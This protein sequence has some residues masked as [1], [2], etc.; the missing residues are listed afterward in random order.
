LHDQNASGGLTRGKRVDKTRRVMWILNHTAA[1]KFEVPMLRKLGYEVFTPK[2]YPND[3]N[4]RSAS[5]D[6]KWDESLTIPPEDLKILNEADW[7]AGANRYAWE[8]ANKY[9]DILFCILFD[10][11]GV[12]KTCRNFEGDVLWRTYGLAGEEN[13]YSK[14]LK[15]IPQYHRAKGAFRQLGSRFWFAEG[16]SNL[17]EVEDDWI[18][19]SAVH[20]PLGMAEA[21]SPVVEP[22]V[23]GD[24]RVLFVCP[25]IG[26]NSAY[27]DIYTE[28]KQH[29]R[30]IPHA[31]GGA[32]SIKV[33]DPNVL[34]YLPLKE[35]QENMTHL[36]CMFYHSREP[37]HIHYHPFEAI[38]IGMP[39]IFMSGGMLDRMGGAALPGRAKTWSEARSKVQRLIEGDASFA[40]AVR[41][42]Q[43]SLLNDMMAENLEE[44]WVRGLSKIEAAADRREKIIDGKSRRVAIITSRKDIEKAVDAA[45]RL[46]VDASGVGVSLEVVVGVEVVSSKF[47]SRHDSRLDKYLETIAHP[48]RV[49]AWKEISKSGAERSMIYAGVGREVQ[50][51][52]FVVPDDQIN[53]FQ[54]CDL[55][56]VVGDRAETPIL[57]LRPIIWLVRQDDPAVYGK[58]PRHK[59]CRTGRLGQP[60]GPEAVIVD[61]INAKSLIVKMEAIDPNQI[62]VVNDREMPGSS[63]INV[64]LECL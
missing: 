54:D 28:F 21:S 22:W 29:F 42:S 16:Y 60:P 39:L 33:R 32:Q 34:G 48:I 23:G 20:L 61:S 30:D 4:F 47:S 5:V 53:F 18:K 49:F 13:S 24:R 57:P 63:M 17:H 64:V 44:F 52:A 37:R 9:F 40:E 62:F 38:R 12:E 2:I 45:E 10:S 3:P 35:H 50:S 56:I 51:E 8:I 14:I 31:I 25:D 26:Y 36:Q 58:Y 6:E 1:R 15:S 27:I 43:N 7:Y 55:W 46:L 11:R 59:P 41:S 19:R